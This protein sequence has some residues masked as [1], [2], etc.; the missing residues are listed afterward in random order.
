MTLPLVLPALISGG[1]SIIGGIF[2][3]NSAAEQNREER[4]WQEKMASTQYQRG[5]AD[6]K[7][8][9][10]N[11]LMIY[12][13]GSMSAPVA[14]GARMEE[15][16]ALSE[17]IRGAGNAAA[18]LILQQQL[19]KAQ[20]A[21]MASA[22]E[23][24]RAAAYEHNERGDNINWETTRSRN[25]FQLDYGGQSVEAWQRNR[26]AV[27]ENLVKESLARQ[28]NL[29]AQAAEAA[30]RKALIE[31]EKEML[32]K[33]RSFADAWKTY[34]DQVGVGGAYVE[35][36]GKL[37]TQVAGSLGIG[38]IGKALLGPGQR[39]GGAASAKQ[40]ERMENVFEYNNNQS[41]MIGR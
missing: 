21:E 20:I 12:G 32:E 39:S 36:G 4:A 11:P 40:A 6:M 25:L 28:G 14:G 13:K 9:G 7:A 19:Q 22:A 29:N 5:V 33:K 18:Q 16:K 1:S 30:A 17:G 3:S 23:A 2:G 10:L 26:V 31:I 35:V 41:D 34:W 38:A 15:G 8:A 24:N 37:F 27:A